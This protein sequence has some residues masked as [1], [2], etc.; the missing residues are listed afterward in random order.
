VACVRDEEQAMPEVGGGLLAVLADEAPGQL[1][2][3]E[4]W[5]EDDHLYERSAIEGFLYSRRYISV[6]G[7]PRSLTL[8]EIDGPEVLHGAGYAK[9]WER[10]NAIAARRREAGDP[11]P[12]RMTGMIRNEYALISATGR[13]VGEIGAFIWMVREDVPEGREAALDHW[14]DQEHLPLVTAMG[15]VRG[16]RRYR[17]TVGTPRYLTVYDLANA[18]A[19]ESAA[20]R[21]SFQTPGAGILEERTEVITNLARFF[22]YVD[23]A[24]ALREMAK[25]PE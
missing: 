9:A 21:D 15:T 18:D 11:I 7:Q 3:M 6:Q 12:Q 17:A 1:E 14:Y 22:K 20:W 13:H 10:E 19:I 25:W 16:V 23:H 4:R 24:E 2:E 5:Y 8:Y